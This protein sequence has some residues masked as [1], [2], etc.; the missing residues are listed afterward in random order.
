MPE[1]NGRLLSVAGAYDLPGTPS[2]YQPRENRLTFEV[3][4]VTTV[5]FDQ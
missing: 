3:G 5:L 4:F 2:V 1:P